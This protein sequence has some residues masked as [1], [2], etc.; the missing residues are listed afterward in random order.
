MIWPTDYTF[1]N[2]TNTFFIDGWSIGKSI[3]FIVLRQILYTVVTVVTMYFFFKVYFKSTMKLDKLNKIFLPAI[4]KETLFIYL[5]HL[6]LVS[7]LLRY[8][9]RYVTNNVG[10]LPN[11]PFLRYY[12]IAPF[13]TVIIAYISHWLFGKIEKNQWMAK[14]LLGK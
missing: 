12:V 7:Y 10:I 8:S 5:F 6:I 3:L 4:G 13:L 2:I 1:Y 11:A 14:L 9:I